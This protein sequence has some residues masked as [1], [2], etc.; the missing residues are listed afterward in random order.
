MSLLQSLAA[1]LRRSAA[2]AA[3]HLAAAAPQAGWV[4]ARPASKVQFEK[5]VID[6]VLFRF[7][8]IDSAKVSLK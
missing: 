1:Q 6:V 5:C 2:A 3:V 4:R 8:L 7:N